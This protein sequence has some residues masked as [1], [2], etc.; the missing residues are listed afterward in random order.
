MAESEQGI[1]TAIVAQYRPYDTLRRTNDPVWLEICT[2][3][4]NAA[5]IQYRGSQV[6]LG[7]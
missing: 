1:L 7:R 2:P 5:V 4:R 6:A 3:I